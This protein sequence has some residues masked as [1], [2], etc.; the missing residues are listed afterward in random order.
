MISPISRRTIFTNFTHN[1]VDRC[2]NLNF[3]NRILEIFSQ[4][5]VF[6][7]KNAKISRKCSNSGDFRP[8]ELRNDNTS[9]ETHGQHNLYGMSSF[10]FYC[11]NPSL[12]TPH[13]NVRTHK[14]YAVDDRMRITALCDTF[15]ITTR[16]HELYKYS[17]WEL[18]GLFRLLLQTVTVQK[19]T[20]ITCNL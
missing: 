4:K 5:V 10:H 19:I 9:S 7:P 17:K 1:N 20:L 16:R 2:R 15:V 18:L 3:P 12:H 14:R 6:F 11:W 8:P 13:R